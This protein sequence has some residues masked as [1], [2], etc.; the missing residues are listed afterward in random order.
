M[1]Y[2]LRLRI[3]PESPHTESSLSVHSDAAIGIHENIKHP[4]KDLTKTTDNFTMIAI[5]FLF[6]Q[7]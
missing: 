3:T 5:F 4:N 7:L 2:H 6:L 1:C